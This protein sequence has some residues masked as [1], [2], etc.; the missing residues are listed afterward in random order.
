MTRLSLPILLFLPVSEYTHGLSSGD[1]AVPPPTM[2]G[3]HVLTLLVL[4]LAMGLA[5]TEQERGSNGQNVHGRD[6]ASI[7]SRGLERPRPVFPNVL[8]YSCRSP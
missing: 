5:L 1:E 2:G 3:I 6:R 7:L 8:L 4:G